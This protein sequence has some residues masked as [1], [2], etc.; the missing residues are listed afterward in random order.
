MAEPGAGPVVPRRRSRGA[1]PGRAA[2]RP[3][4]PWLRDDS[5]AFGA[6]VGDLKYPDAGGLHCWDFAEFWGLFS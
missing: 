6:L 1:R 5:G 4:A 3:S 2:Q